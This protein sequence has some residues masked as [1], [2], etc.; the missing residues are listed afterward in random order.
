M[1]IVYENAIGLRR[2]LLKRLIEY[3]FTILLF[4]EAKSFAYYK[5]HMI[6]KNADNGKNI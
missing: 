2:V 3:C 5:P 4:I 6:I 1:S